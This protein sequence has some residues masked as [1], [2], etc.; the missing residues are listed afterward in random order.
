MKTLH[1]SQLPKTDTL[2][3]WDYIVE[4]QHIMG[5]LYNPILSP[6]GLSQIPSRLDTKHQLHCTYTKLFRNQRTI[7]NIVHTMGI[8]TIHIQYECRMYGNILRTCLV[9]G[10]ILTKKPQAPLKYVLTIHNSFDRAAINTY[11]A[12]KLKQYQPFIGIAQRICYYLVHV[13][14][15]FIVQRCDSCILHDSYMVEFL[16]A[17]SLKDSHNIQFIPFHGVDTITQSLTASKSSSITLNKQELNSKKDW[18][19]LC[20]S[21]YISPNHIEHILADFAHTLSHDSPIQLSI[22][23]RIPLLSDAQ[24]F[25][26]IRYAGSHNHSTLPIHWLG[27]TS[28]NSLDS[29]ISSHDIV[30]APRLASLKSHLFLSRLISYNSLFVYF[31]DYSND[32]WPVM[33]HIQ[34]GI[35]TAI[36]ELV[37]NC[38]YYRNALK[39]HKL[40]RSVNYIRKQYES[41]YSMN[42][43]I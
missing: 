20:L 26:K 27:E 39:L 10:S 16:R 9:I 5:R 13:W 36:A 22:T 21:E 23:G 31:E 28:N 6:W 4:L 12:Q 34:S 14:L 3:E 42:T 33:P 43:N 17:Q 25:D 41:T 8:D 24:L 15:K 18:R 19:V 32:D 37:Y 38:E 11:I 1:I 40:K 35:Q 29:L 30:I 7:G 2:K